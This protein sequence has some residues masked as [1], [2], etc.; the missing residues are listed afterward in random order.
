MKHVH[1][2]YSITVPSRF[3]VMPGAIDLRNI[4][5]VKCNATHIV[6]EMWIEIDRP[7]YTMLP[8]NSPHQF[9][10]KSIGEPFP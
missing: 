2:I 7:N 3:A 9:A 1:P 5:C 4:K 10:L 6:P 8:T